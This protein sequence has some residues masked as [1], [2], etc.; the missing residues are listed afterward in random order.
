MDRLLGSREDAKGLSKQVVM[1]SKQPSFSAS[2]SSRGVGGL[3][4][5]V[6]ERTTDGDMRYA[7]AGEHEGLMG[8]LRGNRDIEREGR[9]AWPPASTFS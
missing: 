6:G 1:N 8:P 2:E 3:E 4:G 7:G 5:G 9:A